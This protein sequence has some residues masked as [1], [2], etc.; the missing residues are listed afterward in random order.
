ME[1]ESTQQPEDG[2]AALFNLIAISWF[3]SLKWQHAEGLI[4][5]KFQGAPGDYCNCLYKETTQE[6]LDLEVEQAFNR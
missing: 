1:E 4:E 6:S 3:K 5:V 2:M